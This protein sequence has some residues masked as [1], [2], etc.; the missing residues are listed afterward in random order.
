MGVRRLL[1]VFPPEMN[2]AISTGVL[3]NLI[4]IRKNN[5]SDTIP[6]WKKNKAKGWYGPATAGEMAMAT[7]PRAYEDGN[8]LPP[9]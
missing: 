7:A 9:F 2:R 5:G 6:Q 1:S 3:P 4:D 8:K